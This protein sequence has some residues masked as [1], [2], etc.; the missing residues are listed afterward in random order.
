MRATPYG[1]E[2]FENCVMCKWRTEGFFCNLDS[3]ALKIFDSLAFTNV[4]PEGAV[5]F[6][7]AQPVRGVFL[8]CRGSVK[9]SISA[10]DGKTLI[11]H[12]AQQ[13]EVLGLSSAFTG[14]PYKSTAET[15]EPTQVNF[16]RRDDFL[17]FVRE[18]DEACIRAARQL[19]QECESTAD[20]I[21]ALGLSHSAAEKLANLLL[22]WSNE[23]GKP[24]EAG[25][26]VQLL[27]THEDISQ[28]IGTS[29]ETVTRLLKEFRDKGIIAIRGSALTILNNAALEALVL[30]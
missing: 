16:V 30:L 19:G 15:L 4:Y 8:V 12:I 26:R 29:R 18:Y 9:L 22:T 27:M 2:F 6:A 28:L 23:R 13:G 5:L 20:H 7:E 24:S 1:F 14:N 3:V 25:I 21:R 11:T 17:K 10:G